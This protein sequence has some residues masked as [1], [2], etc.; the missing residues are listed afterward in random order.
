MWLNQ[1]AVF[2]D[3]FDEPVRR[4][5]DHW[6]R[7]SKHQKKQKKDGLSYD[8]MELNGKLLK[9]TVDHP[10]ILRAPVL[11]WIIKQY[12]IRTM[13]DSSD[14]YYMLA[15]FSNEEKAYRVGWEVMKVWI[16][17]TRNGYYIHPFGTIMGNRRAHKDS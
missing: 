10:K 17:A 5:L 3:M 15:P 6:L 12:Y 14:V 13:S 11:S 4:E 16:E 2:D 1:K 8:C 7:Y 9:Y